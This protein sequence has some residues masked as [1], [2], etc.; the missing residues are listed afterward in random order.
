[1]EKYKPI[2]MKAPWDFTPMIQAL[3][4]TG[5]LLEIGPFCG[6]STV[7]WADGFIDAGKTWKIH[8]VD[9][10]RGMDANH[11]NPEIRKHMSNFAMTGEE[12]LYRFKQAIKPYDNITWEKR[13]LYNELAG[14]MGEDR[15]INVEDY[16]PPFEVTALFY[17]ANHTYS[18]LRR[19][20]EHIG[21]DIPY[22]FVNSY[23]D[24]WPGT[25][26]AVDEF[27]QKYN[28][29]MSVLRG[30]QYIRGKSEKQ[31]YRTYVACIV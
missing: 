16:I 2:S 30:N 13:W 11:P 10:F 22:I 19:L 15:P 17:D 21:K 31:E 18:I 5:N 14:F 26:R 12:Q 20:L 4:D 8:S 23:Y 28:K 27:V 25:I 9:M 3:P 6:S 29:Q 7:Y 24:V 1:M